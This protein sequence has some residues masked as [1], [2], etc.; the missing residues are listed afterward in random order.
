M[1][2]E[3]EFLSDNGKLFQMLGPENLMGVFGSSMA[4]QM[5]M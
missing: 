5:K 1:L 3:A 2:S 4:E